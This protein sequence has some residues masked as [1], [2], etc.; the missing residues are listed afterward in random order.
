MKGIAVVVCRQLLRE[1]R[2][3][4]DEKEMGMAMVEA[5]VPVGWFRVP[6]VV[7]GLGWFW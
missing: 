4:E 3:D 5:E 2:L 1:S 6:W 7:S